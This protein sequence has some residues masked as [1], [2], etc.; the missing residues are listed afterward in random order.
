M[1]TVFYRGYMQTCSAGFSVNCP[2]SDPVSHFAF[3][4]SSREGGCFVD[5]GPELPS[6]S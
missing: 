1:E 3:G 2:G 4:L 6:H 5:A